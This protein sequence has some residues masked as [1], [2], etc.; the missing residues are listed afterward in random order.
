MDLQAAS[1]S[2]LF[3]E[4]GGERRRFSRLSMRQVADL[5]AEIPVGD[6]DKPFRT[7]FDLNRW[8]ATIEGSVAVLSVA[9]GEERKTAEGWGGPIQR[10]AVAQTIVAQSLLTGEEVPQVEGEQRRPPANP[11]RGTTS[12]RRTPSRGTRRGS[13]IRGTLRRLFGRQRSFESASS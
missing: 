2:D 7:V 12:K 3:A 8:A 5:I 10:A 4:I 9:S 1:G 6:G 11:S 13:A